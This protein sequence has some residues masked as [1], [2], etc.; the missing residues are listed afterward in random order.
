MNEEE[1]R[2]LAN[3]DGQI[4][5]PV[6]SAFIEAISY[7]LRVEVLIVSFLRGGD[8]AYTHCSFEKFVDFVNA[9]SKGSFY[10]L[11]IK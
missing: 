7:D 3:S 9:D 2:A 10:N 6:S 5:I 8:T 4:Y 1:I 11:Y